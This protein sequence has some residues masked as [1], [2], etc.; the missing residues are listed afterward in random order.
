MLGRVVGQR[1]I[2]GNFFR[3]T[4][5]VR[6]LGERVN[7]R[8]V[9]SAKILYR[10]P[11][12]EDIHKIHHLLHG[13]DWWLPRSNVRCWV[14]NFNEG[15]MVAEVEQEVA[16]CHLAYNINQDE[17]FV[18]LWA[19]DEKFQEMVVGNKLWKLSLEYTGSRNVGLADEVDKWAS[20]GNYFKVKTAIQIATIAGPLSGRS[21]G[22]L[23]KAKIPVSLDH[24]NAGQ[25]PELVKY[26]RDVCGLQ[27][28]H[29]LKHWLCRNATKTL[30]ARR[31]GNIVG[32]GSICRD[33]DTRAGYFGPLY[34]DDRVTAI[35]LLHALAQTQSGTTVFVAD[36]TRENS[37]A[38]DLFCNV[39]GMSRCTSRMYLQFTRRVFEPDWSRVYCHAT[40]EM[41][42]C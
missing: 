9:S 30:V 6:R 38:V 4:T 18:G 24:Y 41:M 19:V 32:Y 35:Q 26:D 16:G 40:T 33:A 39:E 23:Q 5:Q 20:R 2:G 7:G 34:A 8:A 13:Y 27:R 37:Q 15:F 25:L 21:L 22:E 42:P 10:R 14:E 29:F 36:V 17:A 3:C 28:E 1:S 11:V 12:V 31:L